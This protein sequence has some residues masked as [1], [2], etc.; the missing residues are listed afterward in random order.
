MRKRYPQETVVLAIVLLTLFPIGRGNDQM[1]ADTAPIAFTLAVDHPGDAS[2]FPTLVATYTNV[3]TE[4]V[5]VYD[6][7]DLGEGRRW[8]YWNAIRVSDGGS[9]RLVRQVSPTITTPP[10]VQTVVLKPGKSHSF[11]IEL[12]VFFH[13]PQ[14][15][16]RLQKVVAEYVVLKPYSDNHHLVWTGRVQSNVVTLPASDDEVGEYPQQPPGHVR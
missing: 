5:A 2:Q 8:Y 3:G 15:V 6:L 1:A 16:P 9:F 4:D 10:L 11:R 7:I 13:P 14:K 12:Q